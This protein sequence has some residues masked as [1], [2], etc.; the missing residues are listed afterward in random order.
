MT[1]AETGTSANVV[2][3]TGGQD[4]T[5]GGMIA[6]SIMVDKALAPFDKSIVM[7]KTIS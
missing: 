6:S 5:T 2:V 4:M 7:W 3:K 1:M